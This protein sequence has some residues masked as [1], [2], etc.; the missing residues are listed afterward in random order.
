MKDFK[1]AFA[2]LRLSHDLSA[3]HGFARTQMANLRLLG[4]IDASVFGSEAGRNRLL[5]GI[6]FA[7]SRGYAWDAIRGHYLVAIVDQPWDAI[8]GHYLVAIVDQQRGELQKAFT[9]LRSSLKL[10]V[11]HGHR[12]TAADIERA[13]R[14][15]DAG[16][17]IEF[18]L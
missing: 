9:R 7:E 8:R 12:Q 3:E 6:S 2:S 1:R 14:R 5:Q 18:P 15:L 4:F 13:L 10:A 16:E 11:E 17:S